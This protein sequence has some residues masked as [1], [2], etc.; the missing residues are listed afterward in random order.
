MRHLAGYLK[1]IVALAVTP[2]GQRL[3]SA[4]FG[5]TT[6]WEWDLAAGTVTRKIRC[7]HF[8]YGHGPVLGLATAPSGDFFVS[9][10]ENR[11]VG[12]WPLKAG[13]EP[14]Q[15]DLWRSGADYVGF[16]SGVAV[17]PTRPVVAA[18]LRQTRGGTS[19]GFQTWDLGD[20]DRRDFR[21]GHEDYVEAVGFSPDGE[22][23][24]TASRDGTVRLWGAEST[25]VLRV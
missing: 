19:F 21:V 25:E 24:A 14:R 18:T 10:G 4:A 3:F 16:K 2:D 20:D 15:L 7:A 12:Y 11:G 8:E 5:Q 17:H 1:P 9:V 22:T 13:G 6:I 23:V